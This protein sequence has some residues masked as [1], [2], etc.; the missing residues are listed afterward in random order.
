LH[1]LALTVVSA[2]NA[3]CCIAVVALTLT[4]RAALRRCS[5]GA[6]ARPSFA[7]NPSP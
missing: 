4:K 2:G 3:L 6:E 1:D 5:A 7:E